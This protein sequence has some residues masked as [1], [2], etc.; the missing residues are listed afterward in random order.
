MPHHFVRTGVVNTANEVTMTTGP[1][2]SQSLTVHLG[3]LSYVE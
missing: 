3:V 1:H 2:L